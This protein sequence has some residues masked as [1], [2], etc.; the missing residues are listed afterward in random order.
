MPYVASFSGGKDSTAM[1]I[2]I[3]K[4]NLPLDEILYVDLGDWILPEMQ[5]HLKHVEEYME[6]DI[7][8]VDIYPLL[9]EG[10]KKHG[11]PT[12][13]MRWC[14]GLKRDYLNK[15]LRKYRPSLLMQYVGISY[16]EKDRANS[17][18]VNRCR[19]T[20]NFPLIKYE[21]THQMCLDLCIKEGF[22]IFSKNFRSG[23]WCCPFQ[24]VSELKNLYLNYPQYW[25]KLKKMQD[26]STLE[27][28]QGSP[29]S[30][31]DERF[32]MEDYK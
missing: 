24:K 5:E 26:A 31:Y 16:D 10:F 29:I 14:T 32:K 21:Y 28:K 7:T 27:F 19:G 22:D 20:P 9:E 13:N 15:E 17:V 23:C 3:K 25:D 12:W 11:F 8:R 6:M 1:L 18:S 2:L 30:Y 4:K